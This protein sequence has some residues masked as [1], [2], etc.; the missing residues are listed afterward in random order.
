MIMRIVF[1]VVFSL[2]FNIVHAQRLKQAKAHFSQPVDTLHGSFDAFEIFIAEVQLKKGGKC[3]RFLVDTGAPTAV[4]AAVAKELQLDTTFTQKVN[5][6]DRSRPDIAFVRLDSLITNH[7]TFTNQTAFIWDIEHTSILKCMSIDGIIGSNTLNAA[8]VV[9]DW[10]NEYMLFAKKEKLLGLP[11]TSFTTAIKYRGKQKAPYLTSS[12]PATHFLM[13]TGFNGYFNFTKDQKATVDAIPYVRLSETWVGI[14][15]EGAFGF[16]ESDT[17]WY[18]D[19]DEF[20]LA[21]YAIDSVTIEVT[22]GK[23][24]KLGNKF[25]KNYRVHLNPQKKRLTLHPNIEQEHSYKKRLGLSILPMDSAFKIGLV[26]LNGQAYD[27][28]VTV[29]QIVTQINDL[30]LISGESSC[31]VLFQMKQ[32]LKSET[33]FDLLILHEDGTEQSIHL[34]K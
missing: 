2:L 28:G 10:E 1:I 25:F 7:T 16:M 20:I 18:Y 15:A 26:Q 17:S 21:N 12:K 32:M 4:S 30:K 23:I 33:E 14:D 22:N 8:Q 6:L 24:P 34:S 3:Y 27:K 29:G 9:L 31:E 5:A 11:S 13:D 19:M